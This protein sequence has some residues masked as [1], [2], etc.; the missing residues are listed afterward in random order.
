MKKLKFDTIAVHGL[1]TVEEAIERLPGRDHRAALLA[2]SQ[3]YRDSDEMEAAL[4]Y[5]IPTWCYSRIANPSTYYYEWMLALL[6]G[7]GTGGE[8]SCCVDLLAAWRPSRRAVQ[9]FLVKQTRGPGADELRLLRPGLRRHLPAVQRP[10]DAG[11]RHRVPLGPASREHRRVGPRSTRT[12]ASSTGSCRATRSRA[13]VDIRPW[14]T[15]P[16]HGMPLIVDAT[17]RHAG[18]AAADRP[19]RRHRRPVR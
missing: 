13:S 9:P 4:A 15:R 7:Y 18:P 8:T 6:E 19:R 3:A 11:A 1:Y 14:P 16:R 5:L 10:P 17:V 2:T 12:R